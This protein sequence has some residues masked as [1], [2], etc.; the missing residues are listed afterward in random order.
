MDILINGKV[1]DLFSIIVYK[2]NAYNRG[3]E[4]IKKLENIISRYHFEIALQVALNNKI[5][6]RSNIKEV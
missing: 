1:I 5:I 4:I 2:S 3:L 6:A